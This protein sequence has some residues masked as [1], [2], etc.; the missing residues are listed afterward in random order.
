MVKNNFGLIME[1]WRGYKK[2]SER[3]EYMKARTFKQALDYLENELSNTT[4]IFF[5]TETT[6]LN[7]FEKFPITRRNQVTQLAAV[8][9]QNLFSAPIEQVR[10]SDD[11]NG[12]GIVVG[13]FE[14]KVQL[15][16]HMKQVIEDEEELVN[17]INSLPLGE[18]PTKMVKSRAT[19]KEEERFA[20]KEAELGH[21]TTKEIFRM[22][23][24][25]PDEGGMLSMEE[26]LKNFVEFTN[27]FPDNKMFAQNSPFDI[28]FANAAFKMVGQ[29]APDEVIADTT[30][31]FRGFLMPVV[32]EYKKAL[33][34]ENSIDPRKAEIVKNIKNVKLETLTNAFGIENEKHHE[35]IADVVMLYK[36][37]REVFEFLKSEEAAFKIELP[38]RKPEV[39]LTPE[40]EAAKAEKNRSY[41]AKQ[42]EADKTTYSA[43][44]DK[45]KTDRPTGLS[46]SK[47]RIK[48]KR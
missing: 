25:N 33:E 16:P 26:A 12:N 28:K 47:I 41:Y 31:Y 27:Q 32:E 15:T 48:I 17:W 11:K 4:L 14:N 42:D 45:Y 21:K 7:T 39:K 3:K 38:E 40:E 30:D 22:T 2:L 8:A 9:V 20:W 10:A 24:Y 19:G 13:V 1:S 23:N 18:I 44:W 5:D 35:A 29:Q 36:V 43:M 46:E 34:G 6:G 37:L